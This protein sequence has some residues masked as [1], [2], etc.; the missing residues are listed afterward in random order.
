MAIGIEDGKRFNYF[1]LLRLCTNLN[2]H[3]QPERD[4][5]NGRHILN[6]QFSTLMQRTDFSVDH[7]CVFKR[8]NDLFDVF[9]RL[10][11]AVAEHSL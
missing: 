4:F 1:A 10:P 5:S 7:L 3:V 2:G 8:L 9:L 6:E 11:K